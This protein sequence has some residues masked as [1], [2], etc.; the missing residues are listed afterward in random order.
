MNLYVIINELLK[1]LAQLYNDS[2][3]EINFRREY[4]NLT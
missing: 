3:K 2:N 1:E 4:N